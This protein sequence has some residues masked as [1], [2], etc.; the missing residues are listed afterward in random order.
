MENNLKSEN[1]KNFFIDVTYKII[2][3]TIS[4][5]YNNNNSTYLCV[6]ILLFEDNISFIKIFKYLKEYYKFNPTIVNI[7]YSASL[8][9]AVLTDNLFNTKPVIVHYFLQFGQCIIKKLKKYKIIKKNLTKYGFGILKN[10]E[11]ICFLPY[12]QIKS[13]IKFLKTNL[14]GR[15]EKKLY[16]YL[17]RNWFS[18]EYEYYHYY[19]IFNTPSLYEVCSYFLVTNNIA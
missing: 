1:I 5:I 7:D 19:E 2:P 3:L 13:Y 12:K 11:L 8:T 18:K 15:K 4:G 10:I 14:N 16:D 6:F 9:K 17:E